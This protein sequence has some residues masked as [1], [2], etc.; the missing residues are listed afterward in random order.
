MYISPF[1]PHDGF[2]R[3][4]YYHRPVIGEET[5]LQGRRFFVDHHLT[6]RSEIPLI[7][8][9]ELVVGPRMPFTPNPLTLV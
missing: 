8:Q 4:C 3:R 2:R 1:N 7:P 5:E 6:L 9:D